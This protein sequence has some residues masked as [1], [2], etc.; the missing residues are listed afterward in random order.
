MLDGALRLTRRGGHEADEPDDLR[1]E[2]LGSGAGPDS[3]DAQVDVPLQ[4][5][6]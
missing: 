5:L 3:A 6:S 2:L 1:E 4:R